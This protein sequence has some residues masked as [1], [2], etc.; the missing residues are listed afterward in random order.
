MAILPKAI[1]MFITILIKIPVIFCTK[2]ENSN[3]DIYMETQKTLKSQ[4]NSEQKKSPMLEISQVG[5]TQ[6][7]TIVQSH[8]N[9][10]IKAAWYWNKNRQEKQWIRIEDADIY[11]LTNI[12]LIFNKGFQNTQ[13]I[14][15]SLFNKCL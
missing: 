1:N 11:P 3:H 9:K 4:S 6:L 7:Q 8:N 12:Q 5:H 2:I 15:H 10:T 14:K 13:W